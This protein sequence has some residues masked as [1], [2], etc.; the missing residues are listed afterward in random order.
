MKSADGLNK[1][2]VILSN[3]PV[4]FNSPISCSIMNLRKLFIYNT[5]A[6]CDPDNVVKNWKSL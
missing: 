1:K 5:L 2:V 4:L 6:C 3:L